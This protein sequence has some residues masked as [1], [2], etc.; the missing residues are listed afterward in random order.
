MQ[1]SFLLPILDI[2]NSF[3]IKKERL[4]Y[5][6]A[7]TIDIRDM[8][9]ADIHKAN[10][11][12]RTKS[13]GCCVTFVTTSVLIVSILGAGLVTMPQVHHVCPARTREM[14]PTVE[15]VDQDTTA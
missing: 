6:K 12:C 7:S 11:Y 15:T 1:A 3:A 5:L 14:L 8:K 2:S 4:A 9:F 13:V 10:T